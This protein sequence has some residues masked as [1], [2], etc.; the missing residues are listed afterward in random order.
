MNR[1]KKF[2]W[3]QF[4][5]HVFFII[6]CLMYI[7][8][9][10]LIISISISDEA[11]IRQ[12]GYQFIPKKLS[13][14]AYRQVFANP[15]QIIN[16]YKT[17]IT[18]TVIATILS[19]FVQSLYAYPLSRSNFKLK[20]F[21]TW[22]IFFTSLFGG[23]LVPSYLINTKVLH[24]GNTL[25]IYILPGLISAWNVIIMRTFFQGL[26][27]SLVES[28]KVDGASELRIYFQI[29]LPLSKPVIATIAFMYAVGKWNDWNTAL[30]YIRDAD[31]FSLQYLLQKILREADFVQKMSQESQG[32]SML[33][34][35][36]VPTEA[37]RYA[38]ALLAAGP[39]LII[40]P[41]FQKYFTRGLTIGAVKG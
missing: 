13:L 1:F 41:F 19:V 5:L 26:P 33:E 29:I 8:P 20:K 7:L 17:T 27:E 21:C 15:T 38:T 10:V 22:Y 9:F 12:Y 28:A 35:Y 11:A 23:G 16:S 18:F 39:I 37:M 6:S 25:W 14:E 40:F 31:L 34:G 4:W 32:G 36:E 2:T 3:G 24:L 30:I